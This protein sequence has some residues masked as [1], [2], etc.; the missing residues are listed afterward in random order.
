[1]LSTTLAILGSL[2]MFLFGMRVMSEALQKLSG[3]RLRSMVRAM[4]GN[5]F[6]GVGTGFTVT[7]LVQSSSASTVMIVS[8]VNAGLL[9]LLESI[10]P[11]LGANLGTT[12]TFWLVSFLG[13]KFSVSSIA[14]P[15]IGI[16]FPLLFIKK[17][18]VSDTGEFLIGFGLLFLGLLFLKDSVPDI[19]GNTEA[20]AFIQSFTDRGIVSVLAF[21]VFGTV[22]TI[23]VQSSSVA[24]AI[25]ITMAAKGW[26]DY[27]SAAAIILGENV[28]TTITAN[29]AAITANTAAKRAALAHFCFNIIGVVWAI[30]LFAPFASLIDLLVPGDSADPANIPLHMAGFHTMFN[31]INI[32]LVIGFVPQL[33]KL[34]ER[35][36]PERPKPRSE[37]LKFH[38]S[39]I[40][41]TG[42]LNIAEAEED[43]RGMGRLTRELLEGFVSIFETPGPDVTERLAR[44]EKAEER[45]DKKAFEITDYLLKC[46]AGH[47][48]ES[49]LTRVSSLMRV[50]AELEDI[51]DCGYRLCVLAERKARKNR[52]LPPETLREIRAFADVLFQFMDFWSGCIGR[53]V[54]SSDMETAFQLE[55]FIDQSRK[56]LR[57][58]SLR[59]MQASGDAIKAE[60]LYID[61]LNNM[62]SIGNHSLN[63]LQALRHRE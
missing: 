54:T 21:F 46:S 48:S 11:I 29:L 59:R 5:R 35:L 50:V 33:A 31:L 1:M 63:I 51:C 41:Q 58:E 27:P 38:S 30:A 18:K 34:V 4:T 37:H 3:E 36:I 19:R 8:F 40:P 2:G 28:G 25:T 14:L 20:L 39:A 16:G 7:C 13:F 47:L 62:E 17:S 44:L 43:V 61:I 52:Q 45:S 12:T 6:V 15:I 57:K 55:S 32:A 22:L 26:I 23:I 56:R 42:E 24:G 53:P 49:T 9:T 10:G 60:L